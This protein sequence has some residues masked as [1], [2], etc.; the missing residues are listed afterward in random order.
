MQDLAP[1]DQQRTVNHFLRQGM[2][3]DVFDFG[4]RRLLVDELRS[5]QVR[6]EWPQGIL[7][8]ADNLLNEAQGKFFAKHGEG[9]QQ[10]FLWRWKSV[11]TGSENC[12]YCGREVQ[13]GRQGHR[14]GRSML[15]SYI[16]VGGAHP[17][18]INEYALLA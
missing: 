9:L 11:D 4:K 1:F 15:R 16:K 5:L 10:F 17:T 8:L 7:G 18:R 13:I 6:Q 14:A 2:L 3:E 12:L